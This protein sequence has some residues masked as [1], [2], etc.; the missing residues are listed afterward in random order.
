V[1]GSLVAAILI[2]QL[3]V[4]VPGLVKTVL[5]MLFLFGTGYSVGPQF[6]RSLKGDGLR[7]LAFTLVHCGAGLGVAYFMARVLGLDLGMSAGLLSGGLTQSAAIGTAA[8]AIMALPIPEAERQLLASH[9]A[10]GCADLSV[11]RGRPHLVLTSFA[12][13]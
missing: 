5:F 7:A 1:T 10:V 6:F 12:R 13:V 11:R 3:N 8:E 4:E 9:I 2:G